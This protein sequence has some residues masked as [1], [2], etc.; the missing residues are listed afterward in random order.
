MPFQARSSR[1]ALL[2]LPSPPVSDKQASVLGL[3]LPLA[4]LDLASSSA[5]I[6][7][8][9]RMLGPAGPEAAALAVPGSGLTVGIGLEERLGL[10]LERR[11]SW[12]FAEV[13]DRV[14]RRVGRL[15]VELQKRE[16]QL[17]REKLDGQ[18]LRGEKREAEERAAYLS[19]QVRP[20]PLRR[21]LLLQ[22]EAHACFTH[23]VS[24]AVEMMERLRGDLRE[25][26]A[27]LSDRQ[28]SV[29]F[30]ACVCDVEVEA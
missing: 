9:G 7:L 5:S 23:Q 26:E 20:A 30:L 3:P 17:R 4:C 21:L 8:L 15:R 14:N 24:A 27:E 1:P 10:G 11:I 16:T 19:R 12:T 6:Q 25:K 29:A 18:R 13:E 2:P 22:D 28:Q